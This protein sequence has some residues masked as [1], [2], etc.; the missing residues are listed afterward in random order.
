MSSSTFYTSAFQGDF[1]IGPA[2]DSSGGTGALTVAAYMILGS[3]LDVGTLASPSVA[4]SVA[5]YIGGGQW[6]NKSLFVNANSTVNG[7]TSLQQTDITTANGQFYVHGAGLA[8]ITSSG[9]AV[10]LTTSGLFP[11]SLSSGQTINLTANTGNIVTSASA[12]SINESAL[13]GITSSVTSAGNITLLT[14]NGKVSMTGSNNTASAISILTSGTASGVTLSAGTTGFSGTSTGPILLSSAAALSS[15][16]LATTAA[17]QDL[18]FTLTGATA[19]RIISTSS[20][21]GTDAIKN[22]ATAGGITQTSVTNLTQTVSAGGF[23]ISSTGASSSILQTATADGQN[24]TIGS[25]GTFNTITTLSAAGTGA[26]ALNF[27]V[28]NGGFSS[29][30]LKGNTWTSSAGPFSLNSTGGVIGSNITAQSTTNA[31]DLTIALL[32]NGTHQSRLLLTGQGVGSDA[33]RLSASTGGIVQM[34]VLGYSS[35]IS[36]GPTNLIS[37]IPAS[38]TSG[39]SFIENAGGA[40][41]DFNITLGGTPATSRLVLSSSG[42]TTDALRLLTSVGGITGVAQ[43]PISLDSFNTTSGITIAT[44]NNNVPV[45]IGKPGNT[46]FVNSDVVFSQGFKIMASGGTTGIEVTETLIQD[47]AL[48]INSN[49]QLSGD[50]FVLYQRYQSATGLSDDV[51]TDVPNLTGTSPSTGTTTTIVLASNASTVSGFYVGY[52]LRITGGTASGYLGKVI[53]YTGSNKTATV[54]P[55]FSAAPDSTSVYALYG[56]VFSGLGFRAATKRFELL[57]APTD[58][59]TSSTVITPSSYAPLYLQNLTTVPGAGFVSTDQIYGSTSSSIV[60][61]GVTVNNGTLSNVTLINGATPEIAVNLSITVS[62]GVGSSAIITPLSATT[63]G[64]YILIIN[65]DATTNSGGSTGVFIVGRSTA[66]R[67]GNVAQ[68]QVIAGTQNALT[69][70]V[71]RVTWAASSSAVLSYNPLNVPT[72]NSTYRFSCKILNTA[73]VI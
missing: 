23:A 69:G 64:S 65:A 72:T 29:S 28:P 24:L 25:A 34:G 22:I 55:A 37:T 4:G 45:T 60:V 6:I 73:T 66:T 50:A 52:Y 11:I 13:N 43:G 48:V 7:A 2:V 39:N 15:W 20:G 21:T 8:N 41:Q 32:D 57:F 61:S 68:L 38:G 49:P 27:S 33:I 18:A 62:G 12:G 63:V 44:A 5:S 17:L 56:N 51:V 10:Q 14:S 70:D 30:N 47:R 26:S 16:T 40:G 1:S 59:E 67:A 19:S 35:T 71:I 54:S 36:G 9:A 53:T 31:M 3:L 46:L 58:Y 42:T